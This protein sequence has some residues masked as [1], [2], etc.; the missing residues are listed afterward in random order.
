MQTGGWEVVQEAVV[1][2]TPFNLHPLRDAGVGLVLGLALGLMLA[3]LLNLLDR[4][5]K[6]EER[7]E[8]ELGAPV[9]ARIP[10]VGWRWRRAKRRAPVSV[11]FQEQSANT[12]EAFRML[13]SNLKYFEVGRNINSVLLT[14][15]L[16]NEGKSVTAINLSLSLAMSGARVVLLEAD[17]RRPVLSFYLGLDGRR[18]FTDLLAGTS[19]VNDVAQIVEVTRFL[20]ERN[21]G[22]AGVKGNGHRDRMSAARDLVCV[23]A[24]PIPPNPAELLAMSRT[25]EVLRELRAI[26]DYIVVDAAPLLLVSTPRRSPRR[27][28]ACSGGQVGPDP[29]GRCPQ[30]PP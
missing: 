8:R 13:R 9:I 19:T 18:G 28:T 6:D 14:S 7:F 26:C 3:S 12:L 27:L 1:P 16:P 23:P 15:S 24:G 25:G 21:G 5:I 4:R 2:P 10:M 11:G 17:L 22:N 30:D 29:G 20:P